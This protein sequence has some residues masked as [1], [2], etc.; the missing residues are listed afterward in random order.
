MV[1]ARGCAG[2][3][4]T[5]RSRSSS[6]RPRFGTRSSSHGPPRHSITPS[7]WSTSTRPGWCSRARGSPF[8][9]PSTTLARR[10]MCTSAFGCTTRAYGSSCFSTRSF[11]PSC[12]PTTASPPP[13]ISSRPSRSSPR[14]RSASSWAASCWSGT[15]ST[16]PA[17]TRTKGS[18]SAGLSTMHT[19]ARSSCSSATFSTRTTWQRRNR[20][21][22]ASSSRPRA[23]SRVQ[24]GRHGGG[25]FAWRWIVDVLTPYSS[26]SS[27]LSPLDLLLAI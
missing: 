16:S 14:C 22:R 1:R 4:A 8:S 7:T 2:K 26:M 27:H 11:T 10:G 3:P 25:T 20:P 6:A 19:S 13:G 17:S 12:T 5:H 9:R 24:G 23:G 18:C 21:R 15:T